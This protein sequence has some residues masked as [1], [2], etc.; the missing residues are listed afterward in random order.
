MAMKKFYV[1]V[2]G[3]VRSDKGFLII[4]HARGYWDL[5]GGRL[6]DDED[7]EDGLI[8][9]LSEE[10]P[11]CKLKT[12][13]EQIGAHRVHKDIDDDI[14]LV[15]IYFIVDVEVPEVVE[16]SHE[17]TEWLWVNSESDFPEPMDPS[18]RKVLLSQ[19]IK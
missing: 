14:S 5:P 12:I 4:K 3:L 6:D 7:L 16:L 9:E 8:R 2:K 10:L 17:H 11:N 15:L 19:I 13:G 1:G 18:M